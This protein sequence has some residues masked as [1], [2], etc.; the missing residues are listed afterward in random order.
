MGHSAEEKIK[1][2][3]EDSLREIRELTNRIE[4]VTTSIAASEAARKQVDLAIR[5]AANET[6]IE[7]KETL[8]AQSNLVA[9][10]TRKDLLSLLGQATA[11]IADNMA[12]HGRQQSLVQ[13]VGGIALLSVCIYMTA[14]LQGGGGL[15]MALLAGMTL[16]V[17]MAVGGMMCYSFFPRAV[18][19]AAESTMASDGLWSDAQFKQAAVKAD[20]SNRTLSACHDVL[21]LGKSTKDAA[22]K[23]SIDAAQ[24]SRGVRKL[25]AHR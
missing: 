6:L 12:A 10:Q 22:Q 19:I 25:S 20:L 3:Y 7:H 11:R 15:G 13:A 9:Q 24:V 1:I 18:Y 4:A 16:L 21:V 8:N 2:L 5:N 17:G 23:N 14:Y